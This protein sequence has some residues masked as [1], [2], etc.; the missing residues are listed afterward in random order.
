[1]TMKPTCAGGFHVNPRLPSGFDNT[2][3]T[4]RPASHMNWWGIPYIVEH[5]KGPGCPPGEPHYEVRRLDGGAWDRSTGH[6][7]NLTL[8]EAVARCGELAKQEM[9]QCPKCHATTLAQYW[10][11]FHMMEDGKVSQA[12]FLC[13]QCGDRHAAEATTDAAPND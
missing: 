7:Y 13:P 8:A 5:E 12:V 11:P 2:P 3:N 9:R 10:G 1:M 4:K 6:G